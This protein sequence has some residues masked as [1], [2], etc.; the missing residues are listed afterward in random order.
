MFARK[1][2]FVRFR[3]NFVKKVTLVLESLFNIHFETLNAKNSIFWSSTPKTDTLT[4]FLTLFCPRYTYSQ[5]CTTK[6]VRTYVRTT[7]R[8]LGGSADI[9]T[10]VHSYI[11]TFVHSS[12]HSSVHPS[13]HSS[14][15]PSIRTYAHAQKTN[16]NVNF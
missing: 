15:H 6:N 2:R 3:E 16:E 14:A 10:F 11:R 12:V 7:A 1:I 13:V 4:V 5:V 8:R 9:R